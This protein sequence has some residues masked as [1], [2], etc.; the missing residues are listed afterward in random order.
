M[1]MANSYSKVEVVWYPSGKLQY[2][3][4]KEPPLSRKD[5]RKESPRDVKFW[6][7][8]ANI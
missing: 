8:V 7:E 5:F 4:S 6:Q 3:F 1:L 2:C